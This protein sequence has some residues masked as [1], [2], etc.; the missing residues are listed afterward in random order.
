MEITILSIKETKIIIDLNQKP[1]I[2]SES[3]S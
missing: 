3:K 1:I 2:K